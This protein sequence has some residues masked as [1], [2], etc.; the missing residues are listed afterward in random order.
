MAGDQVDL[1]ASTTVVA[2]QHLIPLADEEIGRRLLPLSADVVQLT[3]ARPVEAPQL[4]QLRCVQLSGPFL[5]EVGD[6]LQLGAVH[7]I[8][9]PLLEGQKGPGPLRPNQHGHRAEGPPVQFTG[10]VLPEG[11]EVFLAAVPFVALEPVGRIAAGPLDHQPVAV[12]L[13]HHRSRRNGQGAGI[14]VHDRLFRKTAPG[15]GA[16]I[17]QHLPGCQPQIAQGQPHGLERSLED[18]ETVD[19]LGFD[20]AH[21]H[22]HGLALD[23]PQQFLALFGS[24]FLGVV[25]TGNQDIPG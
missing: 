24:Q 19:A 20:L 18:V 25:Q 14:S 22:G 16:A 13:G 12:H 23:L 1:P 10:T 15:F 5:D 8:F 9:Q 4:G 21:P 2:L 7:A 3:P 17:D 6:P 11:A